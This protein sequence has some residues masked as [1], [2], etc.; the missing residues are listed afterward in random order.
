M[1][2]KVHIG[3]GFHVNCYHSYRG[4]SNDELGFGGDIRIIRKIISILDE[5]NRRGVPAKATWDFE[6]AY[7][8]EDTLPRYA[9]DI[10]ED[11]RRRCVENGDENI[12]M[13]YNN[14]ALSAMTPDEFEASIEWAVTNEKG[15]GL[16]DLFGSFERIV[17][18]QEV[19]F[20]P[21]Q[22]P[23]YNKCG[24]KAVCLYYSCV[25]FDAFRT[26]VP[27]LRDEY[28]FNPVTYTW[29]GESLVILP[30]YSNSDV[31]DAGS[32]RYLACDLHR[33]QLAG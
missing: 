28:A 30:T 21:S 7:S 23:L 6:N 3:Y 33:K 13:G 25:P 17:R 8:L 11:V 24:V 4:D 32:L 31:I 27:Q 15:S 1:A 5:F 14:G 22:V 2:G 19:M 26:V 29:Q 20:T 10:I 12:I 18:P 16:V 9:P